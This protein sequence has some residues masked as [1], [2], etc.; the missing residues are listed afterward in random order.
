M[1]LKFAKMNQPYRD[2]REIIE[3]YKVLISTVLD[4]YQTDPIQ[5]N[6][7]DLSDHTKE[8][9]VFAELREATGEVLQWIADREAV[10]KEE[11]DLPPFQTV[12]QQCGLDD[13]EQLIVIFLLMPEISVSSNKLYNMLL[14]KRRETYITVGFLYELLQYV[15]EITAYELLEY[16]QPD[17]LLAKYCI[18]T[19]TDRELVN[20][21]TPV[22]LRTN[23][24]QYASG[25][26]VVSNERNHVFYYISEEK[27]IYAFDDYVEYFERMIRYGE[28]NG[29]VV[30]L[31]GK[32]CSGR[33]SCL[34]KLSTKLGRRLLYI[35]YGRMCQAGQK[36]Y[37]H[38]RSLILTEL[39][40]QEPIL[41][42]SGIESTAE[43]KKHRVA[44]FISELLEYTKVVFTSF[45]PRELVGMRTPYILFDLGDENLV[46]RKKIW[47]GM[48]SEYPVEEQVSAVHMASKYNLVAGDIRRVFEMAD[49]FRMMEDEELIHKEY[50]EKAIYETGSIDFQGLATR[51]PAVFDWTDIELEDT[52]VRTLKLICARIS[53]QYQVGEVAG[54]N[55]KLAYGKGVSILF[56]GAPGTG[57]T[58][59]AQVLAKELGME[60]YRVDLSQ[61]VSKY[62]GE[63]EKNLARVFDEARKG[64]TILF[65]DEADSLFSRRTDVTDVK[66]K[67]SN[68]EVS[69]LLQK[70]EEY[71]GITI[72]ATN[73]LQN[74]D[75]AI[76]RRLT[77]SIR[78][79]QP[80]QQTRLELWNK[81][82][83]QT[84]RFSEDLDIGYFAERF[85]L[86]GSNIKAILYNAAYMAAVQMQADDRQPEGMIEIQPVHLVK[87]IQMEYDKLGMYLQRS[88]LG[89]Y[90]ECLNG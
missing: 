56:Y 80:N 6:A 16:F 74:F 49:F 15:K 85:E 51:I 10:T 50:L 38:L 88:D 65:F 11:K 58:M 79:E 52:A 55:K 20:F 12:M 32:T 3:D 29:A 14:Q 62:I 70:M 63:T 69:F 89:V 86:S 36:G 76:L 45:E 28:R 41:Y 47:D 77:Y 24:I 44:D 18:E 31:K 22:Q 2:N 67:Y 25:Q 30:I 23:F 57:K 68:T 39:R 27:K 59:C 61:M 9:R 90:G 81:I 33:R 19:G 7:D 8:S 82:L 37:Q 54:L 53:L 84:V 21:N 35:D 17:R 75:P 40:I 42:V 66:D 87:A 46:R 48:M 78:F 26:E 13:T 43:D 83:P 60:L 73:L 4:A 64:N 34:C 5:W 1:E 72:L 71:S